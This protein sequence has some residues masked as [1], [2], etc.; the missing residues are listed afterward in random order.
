MCDFRGFALACAVDAEQT[1]ERGFHVEGYLS[2]DVGPAPV[3]PMLGSTGGPQ[4]AALNGKS[5]HTFERVSRWKRSDVVTHVYMSYIFSKIGKVDIY[6]LDAAGQEKPFFFAQGQALS[7]SIAHSSGYKEILVDE[8]S[9]VR[10]SMQ[11]LPSHVTSIPK[12]WNWRT[13]KELAFTWM[14]IWNRCMDFQGLR[15]FLVLLRETALG[16]PVN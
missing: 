13:S 16:E 1:G 14:E 12:Y 11:H 5:L 6:L 3:E 15:M 10:P 8:A 9:Q 4:I 2:Q 7:S